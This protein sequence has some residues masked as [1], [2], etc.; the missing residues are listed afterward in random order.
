MAFSASAQQQID[1]LLRI[2]SNTQGALL[3]SQSL[4]QLEKQVDRV[5]GNFT[6]AFSPRI[7]TSI[8]SVRMQVLQQGQSMV[9]LGQK[10]RALDPTLASQSQ[11]LMDLGNWAQRNAIT[12]QN[13]AQTERELGAA[14]SRTVPALE[15]RLQAAMALN[16]YNPKT[17][18]MSHADEIRQWQL[19]SAAM[20][21][22]SADAG[23]NAVAI[24]NLQKNMG[25]MGRETT[26]AEK[27]GQGLVLGFSFQQ[28]AAGN[29]E[30][31]L[32]GLGFSMMFVGKAMLGWPT[33]IAAGTTALAIG[34]P[35][36]IAWATAS[37]QVES[38]QEKLDRRLEE[39]R[40]AVTNLDGP[41]ASLVEE[42]DK[43]ENSSPP[44]AIAAISADLGPLIEKLDAANKKVD[45]VIKNGGD[46]G[47][48]YSEVASA[49][50]EIKGKT[51]NYRM[52]LVALLGTTRQSIV[53]EQ[54]HLAVTGQRAARMD[55]I[56]TA[57]NKAITAID[58]QTKSASD[59]ARAGGEAASE[60]IRRRSEDEINAL[61][62]QLEDQL[63]VRREALEDELR[64]IKAA[65]DAEIEISKDK[66]TELKDK[67]KE[68]TDQLNQLQSQR[69]TAFSNIMTTEAEM[70]AIE[71]S[72]RQFGPDRNLQDQLRVRQARL[73]ALKKEHAELN[74]QIK[75]A[76]DQKDAIED[77]IELEE[78]RQE[79]IKKT[80]D[81]AEEAARDAADTQ[82]RE[83]QRA[84]DAIILQRQRDTSDAISAAQ[85]ASAAAVTGIEEEGRKRTDVMNKIIETHER[86]EDNRAKQEKLN[87][88]VERQRNLQEQ[89]SFLVG[90]SAQEMSAFL[91]LYREGMGLLSGS[92]FSGGVI[93][94]RMI[95]SGQSSGL[96]K[97]VINM[98]LEELGLPSYHS[99]GVVPGP[100]GQE[101]LAV[102]QG[103]EEVLTAEQRGRNGGIVINVE[104][105]HANSPHDMAKLARAVSREQGR[106]V[107]MNVRSS[108][109]N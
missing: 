19:L 61:R 26:F 32:F 108:R 68:L 33:V 49:Q 59:A 31:A 67:E 91:R 11:R 76:E 20:Q 97:S 102:L 74:G 27:A 98:I 62:N 87:E 9:D 6:R 28:A 40:T 8:S 85:A 100:R 95:A 42:L 70:A 2:S 43:L 53:A 51:E 17:G 39:F 84:V 44:R 99:G 109:L 79:E 105:L 88:L 50:E 16:T 82:I 92:A 5:A 30:A 57:V 45:D 89:I 34:L 69:A 93:R 47:S 73:A 58:A 94:D 15:K 37:E 46:L 107:S 75:T 25:A 72:L 103:G 64:A 104:H 1:I 101:R 18:T 81:V 36:L 29:Y 106:N 80:S 3:A 24:E 4:A 83:M 66:Q 78:D 86:I 22:G 96:P 63:Y 41:L 90:A 7:A 54:Q 38:S 77:L 21:R 52:A 12:N 48:A 10:I 23:T 55:E 56:R 65:A 71:A 13:L 14:V 35:K 60:A